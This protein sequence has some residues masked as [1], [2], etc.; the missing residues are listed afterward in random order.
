MDQNGYEFHSEEEETDSKERSI[1][2]TSSIELH[3][4]FDS[5]W[6][7]NENELI[8]YESLKGECDIA[9]I[10]N[11]TISEIPYDNQ[12]ISP[13]ENLTNDLFYDDFDTKN[14]SIFSHDLNFEEFLVMDNITAW[15]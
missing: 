15:K 3:S 13:L 12:Y 8:E 4:I 11:S 2:L 6:D 9:D 10:V 7:H 5:V 1:S 14:L